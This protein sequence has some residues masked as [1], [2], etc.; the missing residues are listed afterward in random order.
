[1]PHLKDL[2]GLSPPAWRALRAGILEWRNFRTGMLTTNFAEAG[3]FIKSSR[4]RVCPI[5]N[6]TS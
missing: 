2:F 5:C 1:M 6:C 3:G 4:G